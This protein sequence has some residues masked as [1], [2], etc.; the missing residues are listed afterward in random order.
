MLCQQV[1]TDEM[2]QSCFHEIKCLKEKLHG[3]EVVVNFRLKGKISE[4]PVLV[5][6]EIGPTREQ[7]YKY[8]QSLRKKNNLHRLDH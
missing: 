4:F 5:K 8:I 7:K 6:Y 2:R 3:F 1:C